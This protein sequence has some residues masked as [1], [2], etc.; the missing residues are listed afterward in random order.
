MINASRLI[1]PSVCPDLSSLAYLDLLRE[2]THTESW[3][4]YSLALPGGLLVFGIGLLVFLGSV[5]EKYLKALHLPALRGHFTVSGFIIL[6][7]MWGLGLVALRIFY[8]LEK[9]IGPYALPSKVLSRYVI[10]EGRITKFG[11][12]CEFGSSRRT[13]QRI[14]W[15]LGGFVPLQ[16]RSPFV[17]VLLAIWLDPDDPVYIGLDPLNQYPPIFL[18]A[19][20]AAPQVLRK[21]PPDLEE[22]LNALRERIQSSPRLK[23]MYR[24]PTYSFKRKR[25][26]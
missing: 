21:E 12:W 10:R 24:P 7:L 8:H 6:S 20:K 5:P 2:V 19:K 23:N 22:M 1:Y 13:Y 18:G 26:I 11:R 9:D 3:V 4:R 25:W 14:H 16:G 15:T 17:H